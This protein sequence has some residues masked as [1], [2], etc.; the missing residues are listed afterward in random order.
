[1]HTGSTT[2]AWL[3]YEDPN[4]NVYDCRVLRAQVVE[5]LYEQDH[6]RVRI[7]WHDWAAIFGGG[8][9][10]ANSEFRLYVD[11]ALTHSGRLSSIDERL[12]RAEFTIGSWEEDARE[13][14]PGP[15]M[16]TYTNV[17]DTAIAKD[18]IN[19]VPSL[20]QGTI[21]EVE[22]TISMLFNRASPAAML[23]DLARATGAEVSYNADK[24]VDYVQTVGTEKRNIDAQ[25]L[26]AN[27]GRI[28]HAKVKTDERRHVTHVMVLGAGEGDAQ[29]VGTA[30]SADYSAGDREVW[31]KHKDKRVKYDASA[32]RMAQDLIDEM[33]AVDRH[34]VMNIEG[35]EVEPKPEPGDWYDVRDVRHGIDH[36]VR[37]LKVTRTVNA[38]NDVV[39]A[40]ASNMPFLEQQTR[41]HDARQRAE[42]SE[43]VE[44]YTTPLVDSPIS[45]QPVGP[46]TDAF[47]HFFYPDDVIKEVDAWLLL[48]GRGYRAY[49]A[50]AAG[51]GGNL[52]K[53]HQGSL[54]VNGVGDGS[55]AEFE[56]NVP[57]G[58]G[59]GLLVLSQVVI[60]S[61]GTL[62][63]R[64][65]EGSVGNTGD[66]LFE[67]SVETFQS[68]FTNAHFL[69]SAHEGGNYTIRV[70]NN[71][72]SSQDIQSR[73]FY[74]KMA[75]HKHSPDPGVTEFAK[76]P[77]NLSVHIE[78]TEVI[79]GI[80]GGSAFQR[81][82]DI[83]DAAVEGIFN[84]V[85]VTSDTLGHVRASVWFD[86]YRRVKG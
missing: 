48:E 69:E 75:D 49:S 62:G 85:R 67:G 17:S 19:K 12:T 58:D 57:N 10:D 54:T 30:T 64:Q 65:L 15:T 24:T 44:G 63:L 20:T 6:A 43:G 72:G 86:L 9:D 50:G 7:D 45:R 1:M 51:G 79:S 71:T 4:G 55:T 22:P 27:T 73:V 60:Q 23:R 37:I 5:A 35:I 61:D 36:E 59:N 46:N 26:T 84:R 70:T 29:V 34:V 16:D 32:S 80:T 77:S 53:I 25:H 11:G 2:G 56:H 28:E 8:I 68:R 13:A 74:H 52:E 31:M 81:K 82:I 14:E 38:T 3:E 33:D 78:G 83:S 47:G 42:I 39:T 40:E 76:H 66:P 41:G 18:A 21:E